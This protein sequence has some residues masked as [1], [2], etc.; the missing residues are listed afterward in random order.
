MD[1]QMELPQEQQQQQQKPRTYS[2]PVPTQYQSP[3]L[4]GHEAPSPADLSA[5][6]SNATLLHAR[7]GLHNLR[8]SD[9]RGERAPAEAVKY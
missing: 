8:Q 7:E 1:E 5:P 3:R 6:D 9:A 4:K 2:V